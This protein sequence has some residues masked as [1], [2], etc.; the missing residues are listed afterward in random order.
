MNKSAKKVA[1]TVGGF[2]KASGLPTTDSGPPR[3]W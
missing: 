2:S 1:A 3:P